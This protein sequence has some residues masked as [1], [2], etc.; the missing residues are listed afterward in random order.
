[1]CQIPFGNEKAEEEVIRETLL[2]VWTAV[3]LQQYKC[4]YRK[5]QFNNQCAATTAST[6]CALIMPASK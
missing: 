2:V 5:P 4:N 1:M 6:R 3:N